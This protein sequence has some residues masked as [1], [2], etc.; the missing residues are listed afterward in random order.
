MSIKLKYGPA[1]VKVSEYYKSALAAANSATS[2][3]AGFFPQ[4][5]PPTHVRLMGRIG[6]LT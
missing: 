5:R 2:P 6:H 1:N 3:S 4:V